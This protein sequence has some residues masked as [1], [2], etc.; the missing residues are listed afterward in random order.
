MC[1]NVTGGRFSNIRIRPITDAILSCSFTDS[2]VVD[3]VADQAYFETQ[4]V[5]SQLAHTPA[6]RVC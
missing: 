5:C 1:H 3:H 4:I 2:D 6:Y